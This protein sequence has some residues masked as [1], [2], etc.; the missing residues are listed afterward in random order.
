MLST[1]QK[2]KQ[3]ENTYNFAANDMLLGCQWPELEDHD[4]THI[5]SRVN[6][7]E[8]NLQDE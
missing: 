7:G 3:V 6:V 4:S 1:Q 2:K 5:F 8:T